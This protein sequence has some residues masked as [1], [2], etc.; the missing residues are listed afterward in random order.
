[1]ATNSE[2]IDWLSLGQQKPANTTSP[3]Y[4][5]IYAGY[6]KNQLSCIV[7]NI[8]QSGG[9]LPIFDP[10]AGQAF[11]LST[12]SWFGHDVRI[13]DINPAPLLLAWLRSG[14]VFSKFSQYASTYSKWLKSKST[15]LD[16]LHSEQNGK[17]SFVTSWLSESMSAQ[18]KLYGHLATDRDSDFSLREFGSID[19]DI[20]FRLAMVVLAARRITCYMLSDNRTWLKPGGLVNKPPLSQALQEELTVLSKCKLLDDFYSR[21]GL[22]GH[23][24]GS[25][26]I[27]NSDITSNELG[28]IQEECIGITSPPYA[29]RLD[30]SIMW[31]PE[32]QVI[33]SALPKIDQQLIR[34]NQIGTT[35]IKDNNN[36]SELTNLPHAT[37]EELTQ[38][39]DS[40]AYASKSYYFP[41]FYQ[42]A[43]DLKTGIENS[44]KSA[45]NATRWLIFIRD[46]ARK[47]VLFSAHGICESV[48][49]ESGYH[50]QSVDD[51]QIIR[52]HIG[53]LRRSRSRSTIHGF[54]QREWWLSFERGV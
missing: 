17:I 14:Q 29:N 53:L 27:S 16:S 24:H 15:Q 13:N 3:F 26:Q 5:R 30:Y 36:F 1:M 23:C 50:R 41:F 34:D 19:P 37:Q 35:R 21:V 44:I 42:F 51:L 33:S 8:A 28:I 12:L 54:A 38:I 39:R 31:A 9:K 2:Y 22:F 20:L 10:M 25:V 11:A 18:L 45:P 47:D 4:S 6:S 49:Q 52:S 43:I 48:M 46:T 7:E 32:L 40:K